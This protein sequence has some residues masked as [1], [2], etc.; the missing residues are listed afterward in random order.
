MKDLIASLVVFVPMAI[1]VIVF[2]VALIKYD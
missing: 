2:A 1:V